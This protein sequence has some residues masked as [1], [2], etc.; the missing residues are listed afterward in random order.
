VKKPGSVIGW[1]VAGAAPGIFGGL[2]WLVW[3][4]YKKREAEAAAQRREAED[5]RALRQKVQEIAALWSVRPP[6]VFFDP[7]VGNAEA[8]DDGR[9]YVNRQWFSQTCKDACGTNDAGCARAFA[10]WLLTH[11]VAHVVFRDPSAYAALESQVPRWI[12]QHARHGRELRADWYGGRVLAHF[13]E[14]ISV[15]PRILSQVA[16][17]TIATDTHPAQSDRISA[18]VAGYNYQAGPK[19]TVAA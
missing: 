19:V 1:F 5:L 13:G 11:E 10:Y 4:L 16:Q 2:G 9:V 15:I 7:A 3:D 17:N 8:R 14:D 6:E 18:S 12:R